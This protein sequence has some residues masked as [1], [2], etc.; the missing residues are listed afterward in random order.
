[1]NYR[2]TFLLSATIILLMLQFISCADL[3][4]QTDEDLLTTG[5]WELKTVV[6]EPLIIEDVKP[7]FEHDTDCRYD[8]LLNLNFDGT[9]YSSVNL[10]VCDTK[11]QLKSGTWQIT[12]VNGQ[13]S[14]VFGTA[15]SQESYILQS[16]SKHSLVLRQEWLKTGEKEITTYGNTLFEN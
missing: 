13:K 11:H 5:T 1:M 12:V 4:Q 2:N 15:S 7:S 14:I 9:F 16:V 8:D 3:V 6:N 10:I